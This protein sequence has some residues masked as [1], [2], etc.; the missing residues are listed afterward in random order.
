MDSCL[1]SFLKSL[2]FVV[3]FE[4]KK[5]MTSELINQ[6]K[7]SPILRQHFAMHQVKQVIPLSPWL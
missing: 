3:T 5:K 1:F 2:L 6:I 7:I 4:K